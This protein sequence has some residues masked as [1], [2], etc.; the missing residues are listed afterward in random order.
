MKLNYSEL[1]EMEVLLRS[2]RESIE[3][4]V[5]HYPDCAEEYSLE[6]NIIKSVYKKI[7]TETK[8]HEG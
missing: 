5:Y 2:R 7:E 3:E 4:T 6:L 8:K 1:I